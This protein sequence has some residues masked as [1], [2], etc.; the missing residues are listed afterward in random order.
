MRLLLLFLFN[1]Y[2]CSYYLI[3]YVTSC[4]MLIDLVAM[5]VIHI[6][7]V[8]VPIEVFL[9]YTS[10][11]AHLARCSCRLSSHIC[12][13][14]PLSCYRLLPLLLF[15]H[16]PKLQFQV[17]PFPLKVPRRLWHAPR[18]P[19]H[20]RNIVRQYWSA[21]PW[22]ILSP[23]LHDF[24][25]LGNR[26]AARSLDNIRWSFQRRSWVHSKWLIESGAQSTCRARPSWDQKYPRTCSRLLISGGRAIKSCCCWPS[27]LGSPKE[28]VWQQ[29]MRWPKGTS[30]SLAFSSNC[31]LA[32]NSSM[33]SISLPYL[34]EAN[35]QN[36]LYL[37]WWLEWRSRSWSKWYFSIAFF[38]LRKACGPHN[39]IIMMESLEQNN[40]YNTVTWP[41]CVRILMWSQKK[42]YLFRNIEVASTKSGPRR[43]SPCRFCDFKIRIEIFSFSGECSIGMSSCPCPR[44]LTT[45][46][47]ERETR[48]RTRD[49]PISGLKYPRLESI[50]LRHSAP[51][52]IAFGFGVFGSRRARQKYYR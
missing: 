17:V 27:L 23:H 44:H 18:V 11:Y 10:H 2:S 48:D 6:S 14:Y 3:I 46:G 34:T 29:R 42:K 52:V 38:R 4:N 35:Q 25:L 22:M 24:F 39:R 28:V 45:S 9:H 37:L 12:P 15:T 31:L 30:F 51:F 32:S 1:F 47:I 7:F 19:P 5:L 33:I 43:L 50:F 49:W 16:H 36:L 26:K 13:H 20:S 8:D 40:T 21:C 41:V